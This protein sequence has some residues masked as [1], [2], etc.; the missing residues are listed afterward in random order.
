MQ[1]NFNYISII[2]GIWEFLLVIVKSLV[3]INYVKAYLQKFR[4][5]NAV[6]FDAKFSMTKYEKKW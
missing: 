3:F 6:D 4:L 2:F 5:A 1:E